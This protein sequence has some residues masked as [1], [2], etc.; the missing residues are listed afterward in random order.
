[1][2]KGNPV[3]VVDGY[4]PD[5]LAAIVARERLGWLPLVPGMIENF[6]AALL[7]Q[8]LDVRVVQGCSARSAGCSL[9]W[10]VAL[11]AMGL[12]DAT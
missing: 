7:D 5:V 1:M 4:D 9:S 2:L 10:I 8:A 12:V 3:I 6:A 11:R